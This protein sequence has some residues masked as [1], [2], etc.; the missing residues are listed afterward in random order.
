MKYTKKQLLETTELM[1]SL[2]LIG[3]DLFND[4]MLDDESTFT[5]ENGELTIDTKFT[6]I[7]PLEHIEVKAILTNDLGLCVDCV[8]SNKEKATRIYG[9]SP[10]CERHWNKLNDEFDEEY[11]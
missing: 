5:L 7:T 2:Q 6:P 11:A 1:Q 8:P 4:P 3:V 9:D 10:V